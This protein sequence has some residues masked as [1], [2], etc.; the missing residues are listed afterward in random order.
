M[1]AAQ[2]S[3]HVD[4]RQ[5]PD[6]NLGIWNPTIAPRTAHGLPIMARIVHRIDSCDATA[7]LP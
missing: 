6:A 1:A 5:D 4:V 2:G 3:L 7:S